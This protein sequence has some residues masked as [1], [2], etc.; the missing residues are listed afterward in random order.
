M[1]GTVGSGRTARPLAEIKLLGNYRQDKHGH[2]I[3][4]LVCIAG[5]K[6]KRPR[7]LCKA[8]KDW[9]KWSVTSLPAGIYTEAD[10]GLLHQALCWWISWSKAVEAGD[11]VEMERASRNYV[12]L[13]KVLYFGPV[14]RTKLVAA[15][16]HKVKG[17]Q[18]RDRDN[19]K[20][21]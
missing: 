16:P 20:K 5:G 10:T 2:R 11:T 3:D 19:G 8:G 12:A 14:G 7:G 15:E 21:D 6:P 9:W 17:I 1:P 18:S 4:D 13:S